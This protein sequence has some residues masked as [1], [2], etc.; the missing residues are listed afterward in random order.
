VRSAGR[1]SPGERAANRARNGLGSWTFAGTTAV[2]IAVAAAVAVRS[3]DRAGPVA[4]LGLALFGF[5][6]VEL[7]LVLM[8]ARS[9]DR[10]AAEVAVYDLEWDRRAAAVIDDVRDEVAR[11]RAD[12]AR[13][14]AR[15]ATT[16]EGQR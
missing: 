5:A 11:L 1:L 4:I 7:S 16:K 9:A 13:L 14:T 15:L 3:D 2:L 12:V 8:A 6:V 10:A